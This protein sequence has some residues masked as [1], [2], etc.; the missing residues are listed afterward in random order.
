M[1][2]I[3]W[4]WV[5]SSFSSVPLRIICMVLLLSSLSN[6][7]PHPTKTMSCCKIRCSKLS[8]TVLPLV[9]LIFLLY[10]CVPISFLIFSSQKCLRSYPIL[11][12]LHWSKAIWEPCFDVRRQGSRDGKWDAFLCFLCHL[13]FCDNLV[14]LFVVQ[15]SCHALCFQE[16]LLITYPRVGVFCV[17]FR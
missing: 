6:N 15:N 8:D 13:F 7:S 5:H 1:G 12:Y 14:V 3:F 11:Y 16:L 10:F 4:N 2:H 9:N 17:Q